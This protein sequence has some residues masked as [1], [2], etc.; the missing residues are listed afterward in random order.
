MSAGQERPI[1]TYA[2]GPFESTEHR[3][4]G[5]GH[6]LRAVVRSRLFV[7]HMAA[8]IGGLFARSSSAALAPATEGEDGGKR[9]EL[10]PDDDA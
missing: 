10:P 2:L 5:S 9:E 1:G 6:D 8:R 4:G 3:F 7:D